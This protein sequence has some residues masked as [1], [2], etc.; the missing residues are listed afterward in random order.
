MNVGMNGLHVAQA[1][2][3]N[4]TAS[5]APAIG[6]D[7]PSAAQQTRYQSCVTQVRSV[8]VGEEGGRTRFEMGAEMVRR[9]RGLQA[10]SV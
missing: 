8:Y 5:C 3:R 1:E 9:S 4:L 7:L 10:T 2:A 6:V